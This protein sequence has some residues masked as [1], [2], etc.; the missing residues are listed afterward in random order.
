MQ[1]PTKY[2]NIVTLAALPTLILSAAGLELMV[3]LP[4]PLCAHL[5]DQLRWGKLHPR[6]SSVLI[7]KC[8]GHRA[9]YPARPP[10]TRET[11]SPDH[12]APCESGSL[13]NA[14]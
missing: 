2:V 6:S 3:Q 8:P 11:G 5:H 4:C 13:V 12:Q 7:A 10:V 9:N 1:F 14:T